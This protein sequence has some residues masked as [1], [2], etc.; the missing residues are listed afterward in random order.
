MATI[1]RKALVSPRKWKNDANSDVNENEGKHD[2]IYRAPA[3][4]AVVW[5]R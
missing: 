2:F 3:G 1:I 5:R 4:L